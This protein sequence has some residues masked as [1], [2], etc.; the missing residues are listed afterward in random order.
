MIT[1]KIDSKE[2]VVTP[3]EKIEILFFL[4]YNGFLRPPAPPE[5]W[6]Y[7]GTI[8]TASGGE[9]WLLASDGIHY[10][11]AFLYSC[12]DG[13]VKFGRPVPT[14]SDSVGNFYVKQLPTCYPEHFNL[15][16]CYGLDK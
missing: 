9:K 6:F 12:K 10:D 4:Q 8:F 2:Y 15:D 3:K 14:L 1:I 5:K 16:K 11:R 7:L 13:R